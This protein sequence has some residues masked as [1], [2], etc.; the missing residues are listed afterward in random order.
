MDTARIFSTGGSQAV[1]LPKDYRFDAEEVGIARLGEMVILYPR[2][3]AWKLF[4]EGLQQFTDDFM[5]DRS[6][7]KRPERR[8]PL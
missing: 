1:R 5:A 7:P 4:E 2:D 8:S 6:Q 3:K